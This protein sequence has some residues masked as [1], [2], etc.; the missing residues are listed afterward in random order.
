[1]KTIETIELAHVTGAWG[2]SAELKAKTAELQEKT[3]AVNVLGCYAQ[4]RG[5]ELPPSVP[6]PCAGL[7][8][9]TANMI[10]QG[11]GQPAQ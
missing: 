7:L 10:R 1:M 2:A 9:A 5:V 4:A 6:N 8:P 11:A 3:T